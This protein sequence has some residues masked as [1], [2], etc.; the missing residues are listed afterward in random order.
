[1]QLKVFT[2]TLSLCDTALKYAEEAKNNDRLARIF[3]TIG[4][5]YFFQ[6]IYDK[7]LT[8]YQKANELYLS[9][10]NENMTGIVLS[11][12]GEIYDNKK[13]F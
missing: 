4:S 13:Q 1:M 6:G 12:I 11:N 9:A 5:V 2:K 8:Y 7:A 3:Q 10:G